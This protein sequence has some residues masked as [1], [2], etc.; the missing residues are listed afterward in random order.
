MNGSGLIGPV[1]DTDSAFAW[2]Q[3]QVAEYPWADTVVIQWAGACAV[4]GTTVDG[5]TYPA[6]GDTAG[7]FYADWV[8]NAI[9]IIDWLHGERKNVVWVVSPPLG[10]D[11][12]TI[13]SGSAI[14]AEAASVLSMYDVA[15]LAPH[16]SA[17]A[18][19]LV[20]GARRH[21]SRRT[22]A[23]SGTT[24]GTMSCEPRTRPT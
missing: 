18:R 6:L 20:R 24:T 16:A 22:P 15:V 9:E 23:S 8:R 13:A 5:V 11:S 21:E 12:N 17:A 4:C 19:R 1:G 7:G 2:V 3:K 14:R 10:V